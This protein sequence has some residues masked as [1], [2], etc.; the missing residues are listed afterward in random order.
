[1]YLKERIEKMKICCITKNKFYLEKDHLI[2]NGLLYHD[3]TGILGFKCEEIEKL[4]LIGFRTDEKFDGYIYNKGSENG[5][6]VVGPQFKEEKRYILDR[7]VNIFLTLKEIWKNREVL[8]DVDLV[9]APFFEY[10]VFE[11][12]L[13]KLICKKAKFVV[14]IIGDYPEWNFRKKKNELLKIFLLA[15]QK[16]AQLLADECWMLSKYL[17]SKYKTRNS[18]LIRSSS[19]KKEDISLPKTINLEKITLIF[20]G[21][22]AEEKKPDI[23]ILIIKKLKEKGYNVNLNLVGDGKLKAKIEDLIQK[24]GL[25]ENVKMFGWIKDRKKLFEIIKESDILVFTSIPG[26]GLGLTILEAMSQ[27]LPVIATKCGGPEEVIKD[28]I[29]GYLVDYLVDEDI[30]NQF[31]DKIEFLIKNPGIYEEI[32][33]NN[34]EEARKWTIEELSKIQRE[35][36]LRLIKR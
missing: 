7:L 33:K 8:K 17:M 35:R 16:L 9:F 5:I 2:S 4:V 1:M 27:G 23:P 26:E 24:L 12:L 29:N 21:R 18:V 10:V 11:F 6:F 36:I 3:E 14:Y 13:L 32:S 30:V 25:N 19:I 22:F 15:S 20:V 31:I 28:G 34:I